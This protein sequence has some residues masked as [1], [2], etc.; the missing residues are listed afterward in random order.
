M[1]AEELCKVVG[2]RSLHL[3]D[4]KTNFEVEQIQFGRTWTKEFEDFEAKTHYEN[5]NTKF[6]YVIMF[7]T[8]QNIIQNTCIYIKPIYSINFH[9]ILKTYIHMQGPFFNP[10]S[11][12]LKKENPNPN[13][14]NPNKEIKSFVKPQKDIECCL[15][16]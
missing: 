4:I 6:W 3:K 15:E 13:P 10:N 11:K 9:T 14:R 16:R 1:W 8:I 2:D 5:L 12:N 7:N